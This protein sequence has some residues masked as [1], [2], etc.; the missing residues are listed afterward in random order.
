MGHRL[1]RPEQYEQIHI[2]RYERATEMMISLDSH[3]G[4]YST[5]D[6]KENDKLF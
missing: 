1:F 6:M 4:Y 5:V 2:E 3:G